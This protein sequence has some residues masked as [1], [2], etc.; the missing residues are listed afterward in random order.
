MRNTFRKK[1]LKDIVRLY[2]WQISILS[3]LTVLQS[4][5]QVTLAV[6]TR[7]VIDSAISGNGKLPFW[8]VLLLGDSI[9]I[10]LV[11]WLLAWY[12]GSTT[13]RFGAQL[14]RRML[15]A[16]VYSR[17]ERLHAY[18][19]GELMSRAME[20]V[21]VVCD[22]VIQTLPL[23]VGQVT[24]LIA[25]FAAVVLIYPPVAAVLFVAACLVVVGAALLRPVLKA[26]HREVRRS[27]EKVMSTTQ[28]SFQQLELIQGLSVQKQILSRF[29]VRLKESLKAKA[30][31]R[32]WSVGANTDR[33]SVV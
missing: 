32:R 24:K 13:D 7:F 1:S 15:R 28:E 17:D 29:D 18:H 14:R 21:R 26:R 20:D 19:S 11:H 8:G 9:A 12:A 25:A 3:G 5:L 2:R 23:L 30:R 4:L 16:A 33:K 31:H 10:L 6:I 27:D 22:G